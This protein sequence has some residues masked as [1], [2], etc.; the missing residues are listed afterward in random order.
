MPISIYDDSEEKENENKPEEIPIKVPIECEV[1]IFG[2]EGV[3]SCMNLKMY[4]KYGE[5]F[6]YESMGEKEIPECFETEDFKL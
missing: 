5:P 2:L 3:S 6:P 4:I 1:C